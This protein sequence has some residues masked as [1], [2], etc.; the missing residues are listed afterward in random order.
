MS[1]DE[2]DISY[3]SVDSM[4]EGVGSSQITPLFLGLQMKGKS[5]CLTFEK[6]KPLEELCDLFSKA[7]IVWIIKD[8][9]KPGQLAVHRV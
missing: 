7:G 8:F 1:R 3:L 2:F 5:V 4:Q 9:G 6:V